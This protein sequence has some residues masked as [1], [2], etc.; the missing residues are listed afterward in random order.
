MI[1]RRRSSASR[2]RS[3]SCSKS[4]LSFGNFPW[5]LVGGVFLARARGGIGLMWVEADR[6]LRR[7]AADA[8]RL[9]KGEKER[10]GEDEH[11]GKFGSIAR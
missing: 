10:L 5:I 9:A 3:R 11:G 1:K 4:D 6:P 2:A 8:V 7:L